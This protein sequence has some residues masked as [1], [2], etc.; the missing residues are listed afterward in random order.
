ME[1]GNFKNLYSL[2]LFHLHINELPS[3]ILS[4]SN[5]KVLHLKDNNLSSLPQNFKNFSK[6]QFLNLE[7]NNFSEIPPIL[8]DLDSLKILKLG[9]NKITTIN[10]VLKS[11][12][13]LTDLYLGV[14]N[15]HTYIASYINPFSGNPISEL[16]SNIVDLS[17]LKR[18]NLA[19]TKIS[20]L[21]PE[22]IKFF[23]DNQII[24]THTK[25]QFGSKIS[26]ITETYSKSTYFKDEDI[27]KTT[28]QKGLLYKK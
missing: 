24:I 27:D 16:P 21:S 12:T 26:R 19:F 5:L 14:D 20:Y 7:D 23:Q 9:G 6:L 11:L 22:I 1:Q 28:V 8:G 4:L 2:S 10:P 18:I 13:S 25:K 3:E 17:N 15:Y